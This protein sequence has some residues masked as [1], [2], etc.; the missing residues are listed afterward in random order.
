MDICKYIKR[1]TRKT[2]SKTTFKTSSLFLSPSAPTK[3]QPHKKRNIKKKTKTKTKILRVI[4]WVASSCYSTP[5]HVT[6]K[7]TVT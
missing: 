7:I 3:E 2:H 1:K 4:L 6:F 5:G